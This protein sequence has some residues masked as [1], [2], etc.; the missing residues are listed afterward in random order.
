MLVDETKKVVEAV[1]TLVSYTSVTSGEN[2]DVQHPESQ[3]SWQKIFS[4]FMR[5]MRFTK[6]EMVLSIVPKFPETSFGN[7]M[8][9]SGPSGKLPVQVNHPW[10]W[11]TWTGCIGWTDLLTPAL[12]IQSPC[13][14]LLVISVL[15]MTINLQI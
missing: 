8:E 3:V 15:F 11:F 4:R 2:V 10:R 1:R 9:R 13:Y 14:Q 12:R 5:V 6:V 7:L